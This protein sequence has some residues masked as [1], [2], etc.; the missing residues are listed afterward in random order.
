M[1]E[2]TQAEKRIEHAVNLLLSIAPGFFPNNGKLTSQQR[3]KEG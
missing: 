3:L 1:G 2:N